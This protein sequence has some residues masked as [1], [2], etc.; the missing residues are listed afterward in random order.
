MLISILPTLQARGFEH[1]LRLSAS[2]A[3]KFSD[4]VDVPEEGCNPFAYV[5]EA[6]P[7]LR[8]VGDASATSPEDIVGSIS[9]VFEKSRSLG[10]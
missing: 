10:E 7:A 4:L 9:A 6:S 5:A 8:S 2:Y 3:T 1:S